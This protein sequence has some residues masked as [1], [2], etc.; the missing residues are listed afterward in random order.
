MYIYECVC[1][2]RRLLKSKP[3]NSEKTILT[4]FMLH[5]FMRKQNTS[6]SIWWQIIALTEVVL[7]TNF[8]RISVLLQGETQVTWQEDYDS[9][10]IW[11]KLFY[12]CF[13][14][15]HTNAY[16]CNEVKCGIMWYDMQYCSCGGPYSV[17]YFPIIL[18]LSGV[19]ALRHICVSTFNN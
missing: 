18:K 15:A 4:A 13:V 10:K 19:S 1:M 9:V 7:K 17:I 6:N 16:S 12:M 14:T 2:C 3:D 8:T 11:R 5:K